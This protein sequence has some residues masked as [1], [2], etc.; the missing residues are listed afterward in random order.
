MRVS[1]KGD[2]AV[3]NCVR[4]GDYSV[5]FEEEYPQDVGQA[6]SA[7]VVD[8][9][10]VNLKEIQFSFGLILSAGLGNGICQ[11]G[12]L[13]PHYSLLISNNDSTKVN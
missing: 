12:P 13:V 11:L 1:C 10:G 8:A 6:P 4:H 3:P 9:G 7:S 2:E 5:H